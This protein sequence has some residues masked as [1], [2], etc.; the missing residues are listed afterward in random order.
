V[1]DEQAALLEALR[2]TIIEIRVFGSKGQAQALD[3]EAAKR[4]AQLADAIH[5]IPDALSDELGE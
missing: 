2:R 1:K 5:N 4:V 3:L